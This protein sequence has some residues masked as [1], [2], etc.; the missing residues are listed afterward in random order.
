M[1][2][3]YNDTYH[4][5][6]PDLDYLKASGYDLIT[7]GGWTKEVTENKVLAYSIEA[8][9][10]LL[11]DRTQQ[12]KYVITYMIKFNET[13]REAW[14]LYMIAYIRATFK[15]GEWVERP[16]DVDNAIK[17]SVLGTKRFK[18]TLYTEIKNS[19]EVW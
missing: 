3:T 10:E 1:N 17:S 7:E 19:N 18:D 2:S 4:V 16:R 9:N 11:R 15:H 8:L 6:V 12:D 5:A 13:W 14:E